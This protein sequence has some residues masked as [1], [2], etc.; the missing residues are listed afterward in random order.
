MS[1]EVEKVEENAI[2]NAV[3]NGNIG[4]ML[5]GSSRAGFSLTSEYLSM[6]AGE[7]KRFACM[8]M[9]TMDVEDKEVEGGIKTIDVILMI[10]ENGST[11]SAGQTVLVNSLKNNLPCNV[12]IVCNGS[13]DL[14]K[15]KSF[16]SFDVYPLN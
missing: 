1:K 12:E 5:K 3:E 16:T 14:G 7:K 13:K 15:G 2:T 4:E 11:I 9:S 10:D 6:E 8:Q